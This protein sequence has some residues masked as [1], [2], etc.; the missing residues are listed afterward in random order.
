LVEPWV[1]MGIFTSWL[2]K[3]I[4]LKFFDKSNLI[5]NRPEQNGI[6]KIG[7]SY[8]ISIVSMGRHGNL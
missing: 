7:R 3:K 2:F 1:L 6:T 8:K 4:G 5:S